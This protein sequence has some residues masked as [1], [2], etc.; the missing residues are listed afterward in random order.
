MQDAEV[1]DENYQPD[2]LSWTKKGYLAY[3]IAFKL[4]ITRVWKIMGGFWHLDSHSLKTG[5]DKA[6]STLK[7]QAFEEKIKPIFG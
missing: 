4:G 3:Q 1:L 6:E 5:R 7:I 2:H